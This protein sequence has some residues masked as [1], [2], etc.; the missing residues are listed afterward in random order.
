MDSWVRLFLGGAGLLMSLGLGIFA[1]QSWRERERRATRIALGLTGLT[2]ALTGVAVSLPAAAR[3]VLA[4]VLLAGAALIVALLILPVG[5]VVRGNDT[6]QMRVDEREIMFARARLRPGSPEYK[7]YYT[8]HPDHEAVDAR[9]RALPGL[10]SPGA[11]KA[12]PLHFTATEASFLI[13]EALREWVDGEVAATAVPLTPQAATTYLKGLARTY[14]AR[15][16]GITKLQPYHVYSHIGRRSGEYGAPLPVEHRYALAFTVEMAHD[17]V[18][19]APEAP[20][21]LETAKEYAAAA[22]IAV[23]LAAF[24]RALGYPA[25]AHIDGNYRVIAPLV[26]RDAGL[27]E[28]GRMGILMT[29]DLGPRVRLAVVTTDLPLVV[30]DREPRDD[31]LDFCR[32]C[33]KCAENCPS[34]AI[35]FEDRREI[36][37]ALRWKIDSVRCFHYWNVI[38]TD[39]GRCMSVCP[40]SHPDS[41]SHN[42]VRWATRHSGVARRAVLRLDDLFY[43][44]SPAQR[45]APEWTEV[46][47]SRAA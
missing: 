4:G 38:G 17:L 23:E 9:I 5:R 37:G 45:P 16:V 32:I 36:A 14:G 24:I 27:G 34:R 3:M 11:Q 26:A 40:Y 1:V 44:R 46:D 42:L 2:L 10:L 33:K 19:T 39:C 31:I 28:I 12:H 18:G 25:R 7:A 21:S 43:G 6:P 47:I 15:T 13:P 41:L 35:P 30:E 20:T 8:L 29:P 22:Q